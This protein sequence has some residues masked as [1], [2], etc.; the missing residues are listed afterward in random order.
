MK[1]TVSTAVLLLLSLGGRCEAFAQR[2]SAA[3]TDRIDHDIREAM[4]RFHVPGTAVMALQDERVVFVKAYGARDIQAG[5]PVKTD[6]L[7][8]IGSITKQF[9]AACILQLRDRGKLKLDDA[10]SVYLP[11]APHAK[12]VTLRHLLAGCMTTSTAPM[13]RWISLLLSQSAIK[14]F[15]PVLLCCRWIFLPGANGRTQTLDIFC[16]G[17]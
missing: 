7:F 10:L 8:E 1:S 17:A 5:L 16:W 9:T 15:L 6:T 14:T 13:P 3:D 11:E 12:E 4:S 2:P